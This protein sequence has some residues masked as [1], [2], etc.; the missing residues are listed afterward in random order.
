VQV[1]P[2]PG[3]RNGQ[4][5]RQSRTKLLLSLKLEVDEL[6]QDI[7]KKKTGTC[8]GGLPPPHRSKG[9]GLNNFHKW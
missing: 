9:K 6:R 3:N 7:L 1:S 4:E 8:G 5:V 2:Y